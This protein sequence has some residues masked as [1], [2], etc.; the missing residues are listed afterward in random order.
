MADPFHVEAVQ[1]DDRCTVLRVRGR[2]DSSSAAVLVQ[3]C[4]AVRGAERNLV[5]NLSEVSFIAS[6]G[7]GALLALAEQFQEA[8]NA[9]RLVALSPAVDSVIRLL[10]LDQFLPI[11]ASEH[12]ALASLRNEKAA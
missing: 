8:A 2:L 1:P 12:E 7:V 9:V 4:A 10:N 11:E 6:S 5:L 3:K